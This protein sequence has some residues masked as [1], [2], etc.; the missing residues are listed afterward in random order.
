[1]KKHEKRCSMKSV[2]YVKSVTRKKCNP[3]RLQHVKCAATRKECYTEGNATQHETAH[4]KVQHEESA[5]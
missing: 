4:K 1:M 2:H 3:K 5:R